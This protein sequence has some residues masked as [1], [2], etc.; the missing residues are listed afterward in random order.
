MKGVKRQ[1][2][3]KDTLKINSCSPKTIQYFY[4]HWTGFRL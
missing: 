1:Y 3:T 2:M 4:H